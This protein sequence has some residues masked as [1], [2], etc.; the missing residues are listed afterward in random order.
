MAQDYTPIEVALKK[1]FGAGAI[2]EEEEWAEL[3]QIAEVVVC[4]KNEIILKRN[5]RAADVLFVAEGILASAFTMND[6]TVIG[7]FFTSPGLCTNFDSLVNQAV[8]RFQI[9]S[10]T[11]CTIVRIPADKFLHY[12]YHGR[13][14]GLLLRSN[15]L[16]IMAED[17]WMTDIKLLST[18]EEMVLFMRE[19]YPDVV[20]E[21][22]YKYMA[23]FLGITAEAYSRILR[24][25]RY[26][27]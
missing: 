20:K 15:V 2:L 10:V 23:Q 18:K 14:L 16:G 22:P 24:K 21:V 8:S 13:S 6:K 17:I 12:Y 7:R 11:P 3:L 19:H 26:R 25:S 5:T 9:M 4:K 1:I 27:K